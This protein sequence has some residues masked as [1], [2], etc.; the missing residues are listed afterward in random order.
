MPWRYPRSGFSR[1]VFIARSCTF[2]FPDAF[3]LLLHIPHSMKSCPGPHLSSTPTISHPRPSP[4]PSPLHH[5]HP[6]PSSSSHHSTSPNGPPS[7]PAPSPSFQSTQRYISTRYHRHRQHHTHIT[8]FLS[9][10]LGLSLPFPLHSIP[11]SYPLEESR[12]DME[13]KITHLGNLPLLHQLLLLGRNGPLT[14]FGA[15]GG[16]FARG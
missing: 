5:H 7:P 10:S 2:S 9:P 12:K 1:C 15:E 16:W 8:H 11:F 4:S 13:N 3:P 14:L 6:S